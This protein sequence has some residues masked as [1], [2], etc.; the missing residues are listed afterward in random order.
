LA[1]LKGANSTEF[2]ESTEYPVIKIL[3]EQK[4]IKYIG[5]TM[6]LC[7]YKSEIKRNTL[8]HNLYK[9]KEIEERHRH[10]YEM[11]PEFV[12]I[13]EKAGLHV[14]A[15]HK[16]ILPEIVEMKNHPFFIGVQFHPEFGS[17]P[18]KPHPL[19]KGFIGAALKNKE[20]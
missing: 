11:N 10:R 4:D 18:M 7:N 2:D 9:S 17:R 14:T 3:D 5:V 16:G 12:D 6:R 13:L 8:A 1:K 15:Y 20:K 19:F